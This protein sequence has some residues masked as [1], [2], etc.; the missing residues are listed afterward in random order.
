[1]VPQAYQRSLLW[2][3]VA[4]MATAF[5]VGGDLS[6][7]LHTRRGRALALIQDSLQWLLVE[8]LGRLGTAGL[9]MGLGAVL[10]VVSWPRSGENDA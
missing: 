4:G 1:M 3:L 10:A 9:I 6:G 8:P 2:L 5:V 7:E